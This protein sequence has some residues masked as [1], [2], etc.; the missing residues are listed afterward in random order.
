LPGLLLLDT[1]KRTWILIHPAHHAPGYVSSIGC[2]NPATGLKDAD[3]RINLAD[4]RSR[5]IAIIEAMKTKM[6]TAFPKSGP[7]PDAVVVIEGEPAMA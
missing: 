1:G 2:I 7:I 3:S 5:V 4:S 6:G